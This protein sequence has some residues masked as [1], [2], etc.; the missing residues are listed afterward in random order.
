MRRAR[1]AN[2][3]WRSP[4]IRSAVMETRVNGVVKGTSSVLTLTNPESAETPVARNDAVHKTVDSDSSTLHAGENGKVTNHWSW[5]S[6]YGW[7]TVKLLRC[8]ATCQRCFMACR[9]V[10]AIKME[11]ETRVVDPTLAGSQSGTHP[12]DSHLDLPDMS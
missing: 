1:A 10:G 12:L 2:Q 11:R 9:Q 7:S 3:S 4:N 5:R 8:C 6:P